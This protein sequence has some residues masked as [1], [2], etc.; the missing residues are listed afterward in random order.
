MRSNK[1]FKQTLNWGYG[2]DSLLF[3]LATWGTSPYVT[4][5][6]LGA[7]VQNRAIWELTIANNSESNSNR[8]VYI[9]ARTHPGEEESFWVTNEIINILLSETPFATFIRSNCT[10]HI[11]PM[12]NPDGVELEYARENANGIDIESGWDDNPL[13]PEVLVLKNRFIELMAMDNPVEVA[14]NMHS[15]YSCKRYFVY[16]DAAGTSDSYTNL[17]QQFIGGIQSYFVGG[18]ENWDYFVSWTSGTPDQY[19]ESWWWMNQGENVMALTYE[20]MNCVEAGS[21]DSTAYAIVRGII[22][23]LGLSYTWIEDENNILQTEFSLS[24]NFPNPFNPRTNIRYSVSLNDHVKITVFDLMGHEVKTL[25]DSKVS[26]GSGLVQ[27]DG[28]NFRG[29][30]VPSGVYIYSVKAGEFNQSR[31]MIILK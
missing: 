11:V 3:D 27:W 30:I 24:Q 31:K 6:S 1:Q 4:I 13:E 10:F 26:I 21:Y 8:R 16:H 7:T 28:R 23:Y 29:E 19:P 9:H 5:D 18:I 17:E 14:L 25:L 12:Y 15:A 2:Y 20:D 22:D